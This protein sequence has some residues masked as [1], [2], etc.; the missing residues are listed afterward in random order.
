MV[1]LIFHSN[2]LDLE[3]LFLKLILAFFIIFVTLFILYFII[4]IN[5]VSKNYGFLDNI[6]YISFFFI[7]LYYNFNFYSVFKPNRI[8]LI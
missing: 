7:F 2:K 4:F 3:L 6:K 1:N 5:K 8:Q